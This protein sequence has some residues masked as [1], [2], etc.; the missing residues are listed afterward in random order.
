MNNNEKKPDEKSTSIT[1]QAAF[2]ILITIILLIAGSSLSETRGDI[3]EVKKANSDVCDR[4]TVLETANKIQF[5][6]IRQW[7][8]EV[9][10]GMARI[11]TKLE[12]HEQRAQ[13]VRVKNNRT[14]NDGNN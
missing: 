12:T 14:V 7:R 4:V 6:A 8:D 9:K 10:I 13:A 11:E 3:K 2:G 5:E 1:Y